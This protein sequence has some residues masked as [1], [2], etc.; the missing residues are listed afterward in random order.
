MNN[1]DK[2]DSKKIQHW[3]ILVFH[4]SWTIHVRRM[5][6]LLYIHTHTHIYSNCSYRFHKTQIVG[7]LSP[8]AFIN[9]YSESI[10]IIAHL[11]WKTLFEILYMVINLVFIKITHTCKQY[12]VTFFPQLQMILFPLWSKQ[13]IFWLN[14]LHF[15]TIFWQPMKNMQKDGYITL[16]NYNRIHR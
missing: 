9:I 13:F 16:I 11:T 5:H 10:T 7:Y 14:S 6:S 15:L 4:D 8:N 12:I 2:K 1:N 3:S